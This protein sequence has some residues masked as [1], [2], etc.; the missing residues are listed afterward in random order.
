MD[1]GDPAYR[2][3]VVESMERDRATFRRLVSEATPSMLRRPSDGTRWDNRELLFHMFL[4]YQVVRT[5]LPLVRLVSHLPGGVGRGFARLLD[6]GTR[7][8]DVVNFWGS[9]LGGRVLS[10]QRVARRLDHALDALERSLRAETVDDLSRAMPFPVRWDPYFE[11]VMSVADVYA[12]P[13]RH[14]EHH[15]R[16]LTLDAPA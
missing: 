10:P 9:R 1:A 11:P 4:G 15:R 7:P 8:F 6:A 5:L 14:F 16:Q 12:Y 13:A 2:Q 3:G